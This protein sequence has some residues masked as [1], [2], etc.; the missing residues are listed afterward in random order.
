MQ[1]DTNFLICFRYLKFEWKQLF[2]NFN[3]IFL[4]LINHTLNTI[5]AKEFPQQNSISVI[6]INCT[7][8]V[9]AHISFIQFVSNTIDLMLMACNSW[10]TKN[11]RKKEKLYLS[12]HYCTYANLHVDL[13]MKKSK[14][15][16][17]CVQHNTYISMMKSSNLTLLWKMIKHDPNRMTTQELFAKHYWLLV[18][19]V[20][21]MSAQYSQPVYQF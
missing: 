8:H 12:L 10:N 20:E 2:E 13:L 15:N 7:S 3:V 16:N 21:F 18:R 1:E 19:L 14:S 6:F 11:E 4:V 5:Y 17:L 9:H